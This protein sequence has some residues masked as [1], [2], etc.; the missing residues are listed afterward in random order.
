MRSWVVALT[1][2]SAC[3][4]P[5]PAAP[6]TKPEPAAPPVP[7]PQAEQVRVYPKVTVRKSSTKYTLEVLGIELVGK[8]NP[9]G[10]MAA[11]NLTQW[12]RKIADDDLMITVGQKN[13]DALDARMLAG[14]DN[15]EVECMRKIA[16]T[17][18]ADR[19]IFGI[20]NDFGGDFY[21]H[22]TML[23]AASGTTAVWTGNTFATSRDAEYTAKVA[24]DALIKRM[25]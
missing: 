19:V 20:V 8:V 10:T 15:S 14:C 17:L 7:E 25:P 5:R 1:L 4:A 18:G 9:V 2:L 22:L 24:L 21:L 23:D 6:D 13:I 3:P 11:I 12:L 16:Q